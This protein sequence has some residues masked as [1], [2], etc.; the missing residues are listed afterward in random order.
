MDTTNHTDQ[1]IS[2]N[3]NINKNT[4]TTIKCNKC[5]SEVP[6]SQTF[7]YISSERPIC[8]LCYIDR[9]NSTFRTSLAISRQTLYNIN[10]NIVI[11]NA[12]KQQQQTPIKLPRDDHML[13]YYD[14]TSSSKA[15]LTTLNQSL[16]YETKI[17]KRL[18]LLYDIIVIDMSCINIKNDNTKLLQLIQQTN[19]T[20]KQ[21]QYFAQHIINVYS[22]DISDIYTLHNINQLP[23]IILTNNNDIAATDTSQYK[24]KFL[25]LYNSIEDKSSRTDLL[26]YIT[27]QLLNHFA[28]QSSTQYTTVIHSDNGNSIASQCMI[29]VT[30]GRGYVVPYNVKVVDQYSVNNKTVSHI[31]PMRDILDNNIN[32][33]NNITT[34]N[35]T[36]DNSITQQLQQTGQFD[37]KLTNN[38]RINQTNNINNL[39]NDF[40]NMLTLRNESTTWNVIR[41]IEKLKLPYS[42]NDKQNATDTYTC[43]LCQRLYSIQHKAD[44]N[45]H[46]T[47]PNNKAISIYKREQLCYSCDNILDKTGDS[48]LPS[49][50]LVT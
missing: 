5:K 35:N 24:D 21:N 48:L 1:S 43:L 13:V 25:Q 28:I 44:S 23:H 18:S 15:L 22:I 34:N 37:G 14:Y 11:D 31:R 8:I 6:T 10:N 12:N 19:S 36:D 33:Y 17:K 7:K 42:D 30:K 41:T 46:N 3:N 47:R 29:D 2:N 27:I 45:K 40:I 20:I 32:V 50:L 4:K 38:N 26:N 39:T 16:Y 49:V 9:F